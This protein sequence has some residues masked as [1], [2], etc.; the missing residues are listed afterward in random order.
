MMQF[1]IEAFHSAAFNGIQTLL[2]SQMSTN[3]NLN[4]LLNVI[5]L[6]IKKKTMNKL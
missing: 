1:Y 6:N 5:Q 2:S 3:T 4:R